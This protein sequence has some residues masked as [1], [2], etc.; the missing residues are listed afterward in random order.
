LIR[1]I[2]RGKFLNELVILWGD[3]S[4][5]RE[6]IHVQDFVRT[7]LALD[8]GCPHDLVNIG[9]GEE[10]SIREFAELIC[11]LVDYDPGRIQYDTSRYVGAKSK[12]LNIDRLRQLIPDLNWTPLE[13]GLRDV[14]R[15]FDENRQ[16]L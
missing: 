16:L 10:H 3:G 15:W 4:Q 7:L 6:V 5:K 14:I 2:L 1:K 12:C 8:G 11:R 13:T 9:A